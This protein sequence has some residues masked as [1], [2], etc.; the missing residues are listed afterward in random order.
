MSMSETVN[1][2]EQ[3]QFHVPAAIHEFPWG[4]SHGVRPQQGAGEYLTNHW[5]VAGAVLTDLNNGDTAQA[6]QSMVEV[7]TAWTEAPVPGVR[8]RRRFADA[9]G[10]HVYAAAAERY[11]SEVNPA[12]G[13]SPLDE[14][15]LSRA[16]ML[17]PLFDKPDPDSFGIGRSEDRAAMATV[18]RVS[19]LQADEPAPVLWTPDTQVN[20]PVLTAALVSDRLRADAPVVAL[21]A[22]AS[23]PWKPVAKPTFTGRSKHEPPTLENGV[24]DTI[25]RVASRRA[26]EM[27]QYADEIFGTMTVSQKLAHP[28][29]RE[30]GLVTAP[31]AEVT[32]Y[33][34][35]RTPETAYPGRSITNFME[36]I[37]RDTATVDLQRLQNAATAVILQPELQ[38]LGTAQEAHHITAVALLAAAG[39]R[40][41]TEAPADR[42]AIAD[43]TIHYGAMTLTITNPADAN[44]TVTVTL[45]DPE[46][47]RGRTISP[48]GRTEWRAAG[49]D[50]VQAVQD[51]VDSLEGISPSYTA[52]LDECLSTVTTTALSELTDYFRGGDWAAPSGLNTG[53]LDRFKSTYPASV[54][55]DEQAAPPEAIPVIRSAQY[56]GT[57][58]DIVGLWGAAHAARLEAPDT[59][60]GF[61]L[62]FIP[63]EATALVTANPAYGRLMAMFRMQPETVRARL[64]ERLGDTY[65]PLPARLNVEGGQLADTLQQLHEAGTPIVLGESLDRFLTQAAVGSYVPAAL[66]ALGYT[67]DRTESG[68]QLMNDRLRS[69]QKELIAEVSRLGGGAPL[70]G[71]TGLQLDPNQEYNETLMR[72]SGQGVGVLQL[73]HEQALIAYVMERNPDFTIAGRD[74]PAYAAWRGLLEPLMDM[75]EEAGLVGYSRVHPEEVLIR[76]PIS[77]YDVPPPVDMPAIMAQLPPAD[78]GEVQASG[79]DPGMYG[80]VRALGSSMADR[81]ASLRGVEAGPDGRPFNVLERLVTIGEAPA[82]DAAAPANL[83]QAN[84]TFAERA[85]ELSRQR[86]T[87]P[88]VLTKTGVAVAYD[89]LPS[90]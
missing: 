41:S 53:V 19:T 35:G 69:F 3:P 1:T 40:M 64:A 33:L 61:R 74:L 75:A 4:N 63:S 29:I 73:R 79:V 8:L 44:Q 27:A 71:V 49:F 66:E 18:L 37:R 2:P 58:A 6:E 21:V 31:P 7:F 59:V 52:N 88:F 5:N 24:L 81:L 39:S 67:R 62:P 26:V 90:A 42:R 48:K 22:A 57:A 46:L 50:S 43:V 16:E 30:S 11:S 68:P 60:I 87:T 9:L 78:S 28:K 14:Y 82:T 15:L 89:R 20:A 86:V 85:Q 23:K 56:G 36:R 47:L 77:M 10:A 38:R 25:D 12:T 84:A 45:H 54:R 55:L 80:Q 32:D 34:E 17:A 72:Y 13:V 76:P 83:Q 51:F 65:A 70:H